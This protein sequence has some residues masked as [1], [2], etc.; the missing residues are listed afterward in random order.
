MTKVPP[1]DLAEILSEQAFRIRRPTPKKPE[2][3]PARVL[4][5][6]WMTTWQQH[7][8]DLGG[9]RL[10]PSRGMAIGYCRSQFRGYPQQVV[11]RWMTTFIEAL[12]EGDIRLAPGQPAFLRFTTWWKQP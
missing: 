1:K 10:W 8:E 6:H 4:A 11:K 7:A 2:T 12:G 9:I 3:D 5:E